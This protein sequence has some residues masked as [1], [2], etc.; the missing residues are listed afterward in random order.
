MLDSARKENIKKAREAIIPIVDTLN[1]C[2]HLN[3]PLEV[4]RTVQKIIQKLEKV[5]LLI[6]EILYNY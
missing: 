6:Q 2:G 3:I 4:I 5:V 1:L